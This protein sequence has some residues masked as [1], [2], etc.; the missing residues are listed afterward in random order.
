MAPRLTVDLEK[1]AHNTRFIHTIAKQYQVSFCGVSKGFWGCPNVAR[2]MLA[3]GAESIAESRLTNISRL[4]QGGI[5]CPIWLLRLPALSEAEQVVT[6]ADISLNSEPAVIAALSSQAI[7]QKKRHKVVLM[8][9]LG[10]L[11]EGILPQD[12]PEVVATTLACPGVELAGLGTNLTCLGGVIPTR[13]NLGQL[14]H[15]AKQIEQEF[16]IKLQYISGGHSS[17]LPLLLSGKLPEKIN[18][19][20]L[21]EALF[22][23]KETVAGT[24]I[25]G[26]YQ[27]C[28]QITAELIEIKRKPSLPT[29]EIGMDSFGNTPVFEDKG[30]QL[31]A[32]ANIGRA[33]VDITGIAPLDP[34]VKIIGASSDHLLLDLTAATEKYTVGSIIHFSVKYPAL[35]IGMKGEWGRIH[36]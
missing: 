30:E 2:V 18:H 4:R 7:K 17:S 35:L 8:V 28:L 5:T 36:H 16:S 14:C 22:L 3:E 19:L 26:M 24:A 27:D 32:I 11:R 31:R 34:Q 12:L 33:D 29:G 20:R 15:Y 6:L 1:I 13:K 21:G 10:D 25:E 9:E 23:G